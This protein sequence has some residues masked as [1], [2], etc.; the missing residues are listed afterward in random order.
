[1]TLSERINEDLK[2][3]MRAKDPILLNTIRSIRAQIIEFS[4]RGTGTDMTPA[5]EAS[6]LIG[7]A[8]KR[9]ESIEMYEKGKRQDLADQEK[10]ELEIINGYLP[11]QLTIEEAEAIVQ[12]II[13]DTG[14]GS[15]KDFGK[16]MPLAMKEL[17]GK[18][19]GKLVQEL[20][21]QKL[22]S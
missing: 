10:R 11:K 3:A 7:A 20:V 2:A 8:K 16:V 5:D 19:D 17:K 21:K 1:M 15:A 12:K 18:L 6:I 4:K 14:A 9:K 22:G 13:T